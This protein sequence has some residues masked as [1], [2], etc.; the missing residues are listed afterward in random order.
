MRK[1]ATDVV[2]AGNEFMRKRTTEAFLD[3]LLKSRILG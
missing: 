1:G 2:I 3:V